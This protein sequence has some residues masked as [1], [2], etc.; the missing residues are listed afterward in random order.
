MPL[1]SGNQKCQWKIPHI[2]FDDFR[3]TS[4]TSHRY[5]NLQ[6]S[7]ITIG[8]PPFIDDFPMKTFI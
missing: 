2:D 5:L 7:K 4:G 1:P 3:I 6:Q 8:N